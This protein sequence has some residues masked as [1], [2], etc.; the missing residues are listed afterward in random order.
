M[1]ASNRKSQTLNFV[2]SSDDGESEN[3]WHHR[4]GGRVQRGIALRVDWGMMSECSIFWWDR[5]IPSDCWCM[6]LIQRYG[7]VATFAVRLVAVPYGPL[8][9]K[10]G[11][12]R[13]N[14]VGGPS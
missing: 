10:E 4:L 6:E 1:V 14:Q 8:Y 11:E 13:R 2:S 9:L 7:A 12:G 5:V 3:P